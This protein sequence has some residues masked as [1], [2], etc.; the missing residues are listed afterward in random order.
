[1]AASYLVWSA[2][3]CLHVR[4][5]PTVPICADRGHR[6]I[7]KPAVCTTTMTKPNRAPSNKVSRR[8][9][10]ASCNIWAGWQRPVAPCDLAIRVG[11][12]AGA[13]VQ[14][15]TQLGRPA[16]GATEEHV[17]HSGATLL[18]HVDNTQG[19]G[20]WSNACVVP[21]ATA[22]KGGR[23]AADVRHINCVKFKP[24]QT[25]KKPLPFDGEGTA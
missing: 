9:T 14:H 7:T 23:D 12:G 22:K 5:L 19:R 18:H 16:R 25:L 10:G 17:T 15:A 20:C 6:Y 1:V 13:I 11:R 21:A 2:F 4:C 24:N 3:T 8:E